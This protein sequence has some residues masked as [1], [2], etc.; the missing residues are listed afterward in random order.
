MTPEQVWL[1]LY[2][3]HVDFTVDVALAAKEADQAYEEFMKR[4]GYDKP[5]SR[6]YKG[7]YIEFRLRRLNTL[8][9]SS[10]SRPL[11]DS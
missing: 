2:R 4:F 11:P 9:Q 5:W 3:A 8:P 10:G 7:P 1:Q 6:W